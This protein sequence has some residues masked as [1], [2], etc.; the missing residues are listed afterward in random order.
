MQRYSWRLLHTMHLS[1]RNHDLLNK[2]VINAIHGVC[3]NKAFADIAGGQTPSQPLSA[4]HQRHHPH[5]INGLL[6]QHV[7]EQ[8]FKCRDDP[9]SEH[10][11]SRA[12]D[13]PMRAKLQKMVEQTMSARQGSLALD[14]EHSIQAIYAA[15][16]LASHNLKHCWTLLSDQQ[17]GVWESQLQALGPDQLEM[18]LTETVHLNTQLIKLKARFSPTQSSIIGNQQYNTSN[19]CCAAEM[20]SLARC[21]TA[22]SIPSK[23]TST[24]QDHTIL[25]QQHP[26]LT[27]GLTRS[28]MHQI[29]SS[30]RQLKNRHP[31]NIE[32]HRQ[33]LGSKPEPVPEPL[34][35][36]ESPVHS[37]KAMDCRHASR[38][39]LMAHAN[40]PSMQLMEQTTQ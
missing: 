1:P 25:S 14:P 3:G 40:D 16:Q 9:P 30:C 18:A 33:L 10:S 34:L 15:M 4:I 28:A 6:R 20:L 13:A 32:K 39:V 29:N 5:Q 35:D 27:F 26:L 36:D 17:R 23:H 7:S 8:V 24:G 2:M 38:D 12:A 21:E 22:D 37:S 31:L 19:S 11:G